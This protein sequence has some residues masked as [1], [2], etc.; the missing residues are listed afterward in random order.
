MPGNV[1]TMLVRATHFSAGHRLLQGKCASPTSTRTSTLEC[2]P[3]KARYYLCTPE[4]VIK[5]ASSLTISSNKFDKACKE[6]D[7]LR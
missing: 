3:N 4:E 2:R 1:N 5:V 7:G 6:Y